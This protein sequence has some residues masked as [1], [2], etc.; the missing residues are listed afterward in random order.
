LTLNKYGS[1]EMV[2]KNVQVSVLIENTKNP[3]NSSLESK[4]GLSFY[5]TAT[6]D[7][8]KVTLL[9]DTG[10]S[11]EK[12]LHNVNE[13]NV[14]LEEVDAVVLSHGHYDHTGGLMGALGQISKHVPVIGHPTVFSPKL[15][16]MPH[17]RLIG[18]PFRSGDVESAKGVPILAT[19]PVKIVNGITTTGEVPRTTSFEKVKGFWAVK[20]TKFVDDKILD[21]QSL[22]IDVEGKGLVVITGC[23]HSGIINTVKYAQ[24]ITGTT[25]VYAIVGGFHLIGANENRLQATIDE[26]K[27]LD[28][29][30]VAPCHCTG[31][32]GI[33]KF[34]EEFGDRFVSVHTGTIIKI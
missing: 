16:I 15:S 4:H 19:N 25:K 11:S 24:K 14:N 18:A 2:V 22:I 33:K 17:L 26:L 32:V 30:V 1:A 20:E 23:A 28:P 8:N 10:P 21:D 7:D 5:V 34:A 27:A 9:M 12:L 3:N 29:A 6:V 31:K 13:L